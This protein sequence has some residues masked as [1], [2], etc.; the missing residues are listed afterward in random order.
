MTKSKDGK[1]SWVTGVL[2][3]CVLLLLCG[4][5][6]VAVCVGI[7]V[8]YGGEIKEGFEP[9]ATAS[10][11]RCPDHTELFQAW[12]GEYP[13]P[14]VVV[15][16]SVTL[17]ARAEPCDVA[18]A[19]DC[20]ASP[21]L[22]HPWG[23]ASARYATII[24]VER[25]TTLKQLDWFSVPLPA[26]TEVSVKGYFGEGI[27]QVAYSVGGGPE[28]V[29]EGECPYAGDEF[30]EVPRPEFTDIQVLGISCSA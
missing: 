2:I 1:K 12:Q 14:V 15:E 19:F 6:V 29:D 20:T 27:C 16:K 28:T 13:G 24:S 21:G 30:R 3:G 17:Q 11:S 23:D 10:S 4:G 7:A 8:F 22:Y 5:G 26:G 25:Y 9:V 18:P